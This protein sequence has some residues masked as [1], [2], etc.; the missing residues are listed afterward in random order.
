MV[1]FMESSSNKKPTLTILEKE[2]DPI[3]DG[4][5]IQVDPDALTFSRLST[6]QPS[7]KVMLECEIYRD[8]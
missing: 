6:W 3:E 5:T 1:H 8:I 4:V 2:D 7:N